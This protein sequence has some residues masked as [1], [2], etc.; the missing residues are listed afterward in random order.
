MTVSFWLW[1]ALVFVT[2]WLAG[3]IGPGNPHARR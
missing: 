2:G 1:T 3:A